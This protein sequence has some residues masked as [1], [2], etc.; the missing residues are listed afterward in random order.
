MFG[1][2]FVRSRELSRLETENEVLI[3]ILKSQLFSGEIG[4]KYPAEC[5]V[6]SKDRA[7]QLH[8][9]LSSFFENTKPRIPVHL[10]YSVSND[11]HERAYR[12]I[13]EMFKDRI[14]SILRDPPFR[15]QLIK[16]LSSIKSPKV[17]FLVDDIVFIRAVDL[18]DF[19]KFSP[20]VFIPT[21]R[22]GKHLNY[23]YT[24]Q[25]GQQL[26]K[27]EGCLIEDD[28]KLCWRW[29]NGM[30]DWNYPLS[31][32]GH[33]F[34]TNEIRIIAEHIDFH[35][36]NSFERNLQKFKKIFLQRFGICYLEA[37]IVNLPINKVQIENENISGNISP[38]FLLE[39]WERKQQM[40]YHKFYG[41]INRSPHQEMPIDLIPRP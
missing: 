30:L 31:L 18:N 2:R 39:Q 22:M 23:C 16:V 38:G 25:R 12:E 13:F 7:L 26:P 5:I 32:D 29:E 9:M 40:N 41:I 34:S 10:I 3:E 36:P 11:R 4:S 15:E 35:A 6:F 19:T 28:D 24:M 8:G 33:L 1:A 14:T 20:N 37:K 17:F 21:L 27:F